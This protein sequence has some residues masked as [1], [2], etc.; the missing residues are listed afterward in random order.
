MNRNNLR[1]KLTDDAKCKSETRTSTIGPQSEDW[2]TVY[3]RVHTHAFGTPLRV[4][5]H[6][7]GMRVW[8]VDGNEYLDFLAG[9]AVNSLGYAHPKWV[10]A[11]RDQAGKV[12][13]VSNYFASVPQIELAEKLL[14][15]AGAPGGSRVYFANSGAEANE[16]AIKM[17]RLYGRSLAEDNAENS[18]Q[19]VRIIAL[20]QAFH[21]RTMGALSATW[22][23]SIRESF[24]PL[25]PA[26]EFVEA[27]DLSALGAA[28]DKEN[29]KNAGPVAAVMVELI[30][31]EAGV[32]PLDPEYVK[33]VRRL[34]DEYRALLI[35]DEVQTGIGRTGQWFAFQRDDLSGGI[36]PDIITFAKGVAGGFPMGGMIAFGKPLASL[37][38]HGL[39]GSTFA[40]GPLAASAGLATLR[41][42]EEEKLLGNAEDRGQQLRK[43]VISCGNPLF[44][45]VRGRGLLDAIELSHPCAHAAMEW[46]LDHGLIVNAVARDAL[47]LAP[48][49]IA[50]A[51]DVREAVSILSRVPV[52][53]PDD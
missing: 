42:I 32:R 30:Q 3:E 28:F 19:T 39:H 24:E 25:L 14:E 11:L 15:I 27:G 18:E 16:A 44:V 17:A 6:G 23:P 47:R 1:R 35:V 26:V 38:S 43:A 34:C 2:I 45:S 52:D 13:H 49:L 36:N 7:K 22:K 10:S 51:A 37:F 31:G 12:A 20:T 8:D 5:D 48:P 46:A 41:T 50:S 33:G 21:G 4:M 9:I 53:L 40:G 29:D